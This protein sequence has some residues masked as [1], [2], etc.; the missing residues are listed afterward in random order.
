MLSESKGKN[1]KHPD[2]LTYKRLLKRKDSA[3]IS[4]LSG[5]HRTHVRLVLNG[6][7]PMSDKILSAILK[8]LDERERME[9]RISRFSKTAK[10][11]GKT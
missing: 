1:I 9:K 10:G 6:Y 8:I 7:R 3:K 4:E 2:N 5:F 11:H